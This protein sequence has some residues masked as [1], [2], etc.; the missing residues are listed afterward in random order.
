MVSN[1]FVN[2]GLF[3][4]FGCFNMDSGVNFVL[5]AEQAPYA[6]RGGFCG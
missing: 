4:V 1:E 2:F 5:L 3:F 6:A